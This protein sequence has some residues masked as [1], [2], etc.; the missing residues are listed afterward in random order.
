MHPNALT[1]TLTRR[2]IERHPVILSSQPVETLFGEV[3]AP[4]EATE[5]G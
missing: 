1:H 5:L 2:H 4:A 3:A